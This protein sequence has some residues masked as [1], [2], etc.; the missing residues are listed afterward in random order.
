[1]FS[2][3]TQFAIEIASRLF[4]FIETLAD[5]S[6]R[7]IFLDPGN[8]VFGVQRNTIPCEDIRF[9]KFLTD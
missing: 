9:G 7:I 1:M 3:A 4:V 5:I 2:F 8:D 6:L